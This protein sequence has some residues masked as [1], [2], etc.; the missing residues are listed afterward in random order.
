VL[1]FSELCIERPVGTNGNNEVL[2]LLCK[3]F[4]QSEYKIIE[5]PF[6]CTVWKSNNSFIEQNNKKIKI[7][8]GPFSRELKGSFPLKY[9]S[10]LSELQCIKNFIGILVF[11]NELSKNGIF[12]K[13]FPFYFPDEDKLMYEIL[14]NLNPNGIIAI[15][16]QDPV[17]GLNPFPVF[18]DANM[19]TP[20]AYVSSLENITETGNIS[21]EINSL[22][23]KERSK[24]II[25]R[26]DGLSKGIILIAAHM[27]TK[28]FTNGAIDNA[29]G[30]FTLCET[31]ELLKD[32][33]CKHTIE[34]VPFNGEESPEAPGQL[35]YLN[36]L[37][38][39]NSKIKSVINIDSVGHIGSDNVFSFYNFSN[40]VK[41]EI[42]NKNNLQEGE[43]W[44]SGDHGMFV[45]QN[46]PCIAITAGDIFS[47]L[48]KITHTKND[49]MELVDINQLKSLSTTIA[50]IVKMIEDKL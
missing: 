29:S 3:A 11:I 35:A 36:Y 49:K 39:N 12:P 30:L 34:I 38:Q 1:N 26:K 33:V 43:Q 40:K 50:N 20:T 9:V 14:E 7:F 4:Y 19:E 44:Y 17:S 22:I 46:L 48:M 24:Q 10:T 15:T 8:P 37:E 6:D 2:D 45:F 5:L 42:I 18:E 41:K 31:A 21:V 13:D 32:I 23:R 27:D 25:F 28:Y 16:G 47:D